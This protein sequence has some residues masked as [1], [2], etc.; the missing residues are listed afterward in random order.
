MHGK[1]P[2]YSY[3]NEDNLRAFE[4]RSKKIIILWMTL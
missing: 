3:D 2:I 1:V 4:E